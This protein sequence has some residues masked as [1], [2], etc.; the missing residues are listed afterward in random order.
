MP[1]RLTI[2]DKLLFPVQAFFNAVDDESFIRVMNSLA[3]G[4]G[5][6]INECD[7][8]FP[9]D[10]DPGEELFQGARFSLFEQSAVISHQE[11]ASYIKKVSN[12]FVDRYPTEQDNVA[13][14][15]SRL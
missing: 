6:S 14:I 13:R 11:L 15:L 2:D 9:G 8:S 12:G 10:L 5:Y 7:C 4:V 3:N 1:V